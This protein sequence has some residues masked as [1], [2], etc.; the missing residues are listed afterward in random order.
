L[1]GFF[2]GKNMET[3]K[4]GR[5]IDQVAA[6]NV[7][8]KQVCVFETEV[9]NGRISEVQAGML[10]QRAAGR[11]ILLHGKHLSEQINI[12]PDWSFKVL[13]TGCVSLVRP[14]SVHP[15]IKESYETW[16]THRGL[17]KNALER[18]TRNE[19]IQKI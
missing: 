13:D 4:P 6:I 10:M 15:D 11:F 7:L 14:W 9:K 17:I 18:K 3:L 12:A 19:Y 8:N 16:W 5:K 2:N 1:K